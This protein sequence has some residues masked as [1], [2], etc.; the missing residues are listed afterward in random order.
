MIRSRLQYLGSFAAPVFEFPQQLI[1][2]A[3]PGFV[4]TTREQRPQTALAECMDFKR[5]RWTLQ[6]FLNRF[7][8]LKKVQDLGNPGSRNAFAG[9]DSRLRQMNVVFDL[10]TPTQGQ[11]KRVRD[12]AFVCAHCPVSTPRVGRNVARKQERIDNERHGTPP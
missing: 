5:R 7:G 11:V 8:Q 3:Q 1:P 12:W 10:L 4:I 2:L 9:C 6:C